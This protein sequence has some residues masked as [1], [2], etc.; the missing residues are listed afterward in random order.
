[1]DDLAANNEIVLTSLGGAPKMPEAKDE[2][3][4]V[5]REGGTE[6]DGGVCSQVGGVVDNEAESVRERRKYKSEEWVRERRYSESKEG[7]KRQRG[8]SHRRS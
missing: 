6:G 3:N 1:M 4:S 7:V 5:D 2:E 8:G